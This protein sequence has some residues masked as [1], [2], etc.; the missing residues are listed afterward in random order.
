MNTYI[1]D[2]LFSNGQIRI[3]YTIGL[4]SD[5]IGDY[6]QPSEKLYS[7]IFNQ[8]GLETLVYIRGFPRSSTK[9]SVNDDKFSLF[10]FDYRSGGPFYGVKTLKTK[11]FLLN[12]FLLA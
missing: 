11:I 7:Q 2:G 12:F 6:C 5:D 10:P 4:R 3:D 9:I 8:T 1:V